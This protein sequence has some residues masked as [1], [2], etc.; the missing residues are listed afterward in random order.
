M[1]LELSGIHVSIGNTTI[2][3]DVALS[4]ADR[5]RVGLIGTSGSGKSILAMSV[6]G[7]TPSTVRVSGS[8]LLDGEEL[9]GSSPQQFADIRGRSVG[10]V[11]QDPSAALNPVV[12]VGAQIELPLKRHYSL[13]KAERA[14][15]VERMLVKVGLDPRLASSYPHELSGGQAQRVAIACALV[16][17][18]KLIIADEPTTA[19]DA[20][21]Q[22]QIIQLLVSLVDDSGASLL[23]ITHDFSVLARLTQRSYVMADGRI[24]EEG[25]TAGLLAHPHSQAALRLVEAARE[26]TFARGA[27]L[28]AVGLPAGGLG[29][30]Q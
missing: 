4:V 16:T 30:G 27:G 12:K 7:L 20:V 8:A 22:L 3:K 29:E 11:F 2:L 1:S 9:I 25:T 19:L 5:E 10:F 23:F 24:V 13:S 21:T 14:E 28:P 6:M 17:S 18:P 15:R 26:L